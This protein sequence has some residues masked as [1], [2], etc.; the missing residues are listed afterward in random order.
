[1]T[2][3]AGQKRYRLSHALLAV[4]TALLPSLAI[5][6]AEAAE[7]QSQA[8]ADQ[9]AADQAADLKREAP[10][11]TYRQF[12]S[13]LP[14]LA[15]PTDAAGPV[16]AVPSDPSRDPADITG[17]TGRT[18]DA[19]PAQAGLPA[20]PTGQDVSSPD[21]PR[22]AAAVADTARQP[23]SAVEQRAEAGNTK[24]IGSGRASWYQHNGKTANGEIYN[25]NRLTAAHHTLPF[26]TL[27]KVVNTANGRS[28][29]VKITD[30]TN[31]HTK[32]K[33]PYAIDLSRA[34][35][36]KIGL[37]GIGQVALYKVE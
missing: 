30:R 4:S 16:E 28:V 9:A 34:S 14:P 23:G 1:M 11:F 10:V 21:A 25:P 5:G 22:S 15:S 31:E 27:V 13:K 26:G 24:L 7:T 12:T 8:S 32:M 2:W 19:A 33:R 36:R 29:I 20:A 17:S 18:V 6:L 37:D 35:A 3:S